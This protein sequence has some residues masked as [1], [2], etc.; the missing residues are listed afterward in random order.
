MFTTSVGWQQ[1]PCA[2][3]V[4][5][6]VFQGTLRSSRLSCKRR[7][8]VDTKQSQILPCWQPNL[9][10]SLLTFFLTTERF[11]SESCRAESWCIKGKW[12]PF[13]ATAV[14][15]HV[16]HVF[17]RWCYFQIYMA[18]APLKE[19]QVFLSKAETPSL[20]LT[21]EHLLL[22]STSFSTRISRK[23]E[24]KIICA[25][26]FAPRTCR[27]SKKLN[28]SLAKPRTWINNLH[29]AFCSNCFICQIHQCSEIYSRTERMAMH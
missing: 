6:A 8:S 7:R 16:A 19:L 25:K 27:L 2:D 20:L 5:K 29:Q 3:L 12:L 14:L 21:T 22:R 9:D 23:I 28:A 4:S 18:K 26:L 10:L 24:V 13:M 11:G 15:F 17:C 1:V